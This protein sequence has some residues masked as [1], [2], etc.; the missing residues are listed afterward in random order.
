MIL[1]SE[2][3]AARSSLDTRLGVVQPSATGQIP[4]D[5][6]RLA[7]RNPR[8]DAN[9]VRKGFSTCPTRDTNHVPAD[10]EYGALRIYDRGVVLV[11]AFTTED[12]TWSRNENS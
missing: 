12:G 9:R 1:S 2:C 7:L 8:L 3:N 6:W 4:T 5:L 10:P 11:S